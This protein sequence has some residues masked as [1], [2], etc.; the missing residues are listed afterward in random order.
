MGCRKLSYYEAGEGIEKSPL[1]ILDG[2]EEKIPSL[3][4][5]NNY[6]PFGL[7]FNS[8]TR[9]GAK[10][11]KYLYNGKEK[12]DDLG[13]DWLDYGA[14]MYMPEIGR[15]GV[16]D[17]LANK[18]DGL[19]PYNYAGNNP[20]NLVDY[21]GQDFGITFDHEK[22]TITISATYYADKKSYKEAKRTVKAWNKRSG[23][24]SYIVGSGKNEKSYS[25]NFKLTAIKSSDPKRSVSMDQSGEA[26]S[27]EVVSSN[28]EYLDGNNGNTKQGKY[29]F[30]GDAREGTQTGEHEVGH[31][32]GMI[33]LQ[34][35]NGNSLMRVGG[36]HDGT[37][38][39]PVN[40][41]INDMITYPTRGNVN[42]DSKGNSAGRGSLKEVNK[43]S[44][45][46]DDSPDTYKYSS[47]FYIQNNLPLKRNGKNRKLWKGKVNSN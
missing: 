22:G 29:V 45:I 40:E 21:D 12:Q 20:T 24:F 7:T 31:T 2:L 15:W 27:F 10:E 25:V 36:N 30:V 19:T 44:V 8:Y 38:P 39:N 37:A 16:V 17:P 28:N 26:N 34:D 32:L 5:Y 13:L 11:N 33:H 9:A 46:G 14:R 6:T 41:D 35:E 1:K 43:S 47:G 3:I 42:S 23:A 18:Y 4:F